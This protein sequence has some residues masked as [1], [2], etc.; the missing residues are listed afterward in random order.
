MCE[1]GHTHDSI[2]EACRCNALTRMVD[3]GQISDLEVQ[4]KFVLIPAEKYK[5]M[6]SERKVEYIADFV[7]FQGD[8]K[9]VEDC[10]GFRTKDY[11][12]KRKLFKHIYCK[13]ESTIFI[14]T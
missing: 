9:V 7:Y 12:I 5:N 13:D 10:K 1:H 11:I 6:K 3:A 2:K 4:K 8:V 14:E